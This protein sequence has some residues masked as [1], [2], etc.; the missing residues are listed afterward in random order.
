[1]AADYEQGM[2]IKNLR[3]K[4]KVGEKR[5]RRFIKKRKLNRK[6]QKRVPIDQVSPLITRLRELTGLSYRLLGHRLG[7][8]EGSLRD[9]ESQRRTT[10]VDIVAYKKIVALLEELDPGAS[11]IAVHSYRLNPDEEIR[12]LWRNY[13]GD[14]DELSY[15]RY[16]IA[17]TR[18]G[19]VPLC[20]C[21]GKREARCDQCSTLYCEECDAETFEHCVRCGNY[22][23][24]NCYQWCEK[25]EGGHGPFCADCIEQCSTCQNNF[26]IDGKYDVRDGWVTAPGCISRHDCD[27]FA[28]RKNPDNWIDTYFL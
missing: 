28:F 16:V 24:E 25:C 12:V 3:I 10:N 18:A 6:V 2:S 11:E 20:R 26:C 15:Q 13:T 17:E 4:H 19:M 22:I 9:Y 7:I 8:T 5:V 21:G 1:L 23:C 14:G 27:S